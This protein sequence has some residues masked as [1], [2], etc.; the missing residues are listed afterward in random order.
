MFC[1]CAQFLRHHQLRLRLYRLLGKLDLDKPIVQVP[2]FSEKAADYLDERVTAIM[3]RHLLQDHAGWVIDRSNDPMFEHSPP[4]PNGIA[5][6]LSA[7]KLQAD[8]GQLYSYSNLNFC[9]AQLA[10]EKSTR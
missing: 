5:R 4:C 8:P 6:W 1:F 7:Q 3:L 10:I 9:L 2:G